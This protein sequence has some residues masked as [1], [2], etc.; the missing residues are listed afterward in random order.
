MQ[1]TVCGECAAASTLGTFHIRDLDRAAAVLCGL[2]QLG[3]FIVAEQLDLAHSR[4][5][6]CGSC[7]EGARFVALTLTNSKGNHQ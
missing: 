3:A 6:C 4:C 2:H 1:V 7:S 5:D